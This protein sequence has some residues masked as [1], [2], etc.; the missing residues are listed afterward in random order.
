VKAIVIAGTW[1]STAAPD[2]LW[3]V[4]VDLETWPRWW[5]A[6]QEVESLGGGAGEPD[7]AR[8]TFDTPSKLP[9]LRVDV[10]VTDREPPHRLLLRADGGPLT[11]RGELAVTSDDDRSA[12]SFELQLRVRSLLFK[13]LERVLENAT[14]SRGRDRL[15]RAGDELA[16]LAGGEPLEHDL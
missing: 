7:A 4:I 14:R 12:T 3:R 16:R 8:L 6:I 15:A 5:P 9:P 1:R 11:G 13:P 2:D 10:H